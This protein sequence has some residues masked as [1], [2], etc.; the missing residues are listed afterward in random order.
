MTRAGR[1]P[2]EDVKRRLVS[3]CQEVG[4]TTAKATMRLLPGSDARIIHVAASFPDWPH[5]SP[6]MALM[7]WVPTSG[8]WPDFVDMR[9]CATE[10]DPAQMG[11]P[12]M[13][14]RDNVSFADLIEQLRQALDEREQVIAAIKMGIPGPYRFGRSVWERFDPSEDITSTQT[15]PPDN[16]G[17]VTD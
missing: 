14:G 17:D 1:E 9:C 11:A 7:V 5:K 8:Q 3:A 13:R 2:A 6:T 16:P 10:G 15:P 4:L 12:W